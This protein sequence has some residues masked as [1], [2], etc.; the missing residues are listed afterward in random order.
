MSAAAAGAAVM[1]FFQIA[2]VSFWSLRPDNIMQSGDPWQRFN[3]SAMSLLRPAAK[4]PA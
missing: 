1:V 2:M 3:H 4:S